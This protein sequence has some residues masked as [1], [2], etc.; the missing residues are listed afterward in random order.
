VGEIAELGDGVR[1]L[2]LG[3]RVVVSFQLS[4][5]RC[6]ACVAG[7]TANCEAYPVLSDYGMQPLSGVEYGGVLS[8]RILVPHANA[9]LRPLPAGV[10]PVDAA[11]VSDN[12]L[13]GYRAVAPHLRAQPGSDVLIVSHGTPSISLYAAQAALA[14]G[15]GRV[16]FACA[17]E[18]CLALAERLGA[19]ALPAD[20]GKA[21]RTYP[22]VVDA[23]TRADGLDFALH[24]T[25][26]EGVCQSLSVY[27][28]PP[29]MPL[30]R[31]CSASVS[32]SGAA[33][34]RRCCRRCSN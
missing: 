15:A 10:S 5:G 31:L 28:T 19:R 34:R 9:M 26:R 11:S 30:L 27:L 7:H 4:C 18:D 14:L 1:S 32:S 2:A 33:T 29:P 24:S 21:T 12:A 22:I 6:R 3:Q 25:E 20:F 16:D 17:D 23:G 8:D 13:D